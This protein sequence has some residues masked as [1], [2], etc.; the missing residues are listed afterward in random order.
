MFILPHAK[1]FIFVLFA[2]SIFLVWCLWLD[3]ESDKS[4]V[5]SQWQNNSWANNNQ[6]IESNTTTNNQ[7]INSVSDID[8]DYWTWKTTDSS[9]DKNQSWTTYSNSNSNKDKSSN[10]DDFLL[11]WSN[12]TSTNIRYRKDP[13]KSF[14]SEISNSQEL[15][16]YHFYDEEYVSDQWFI[17]NISK[18]QSSIPPNV[19]IISLNR[20]KYEKL[21]ESFNVNWP[22]TFV[23][24]QQWDVVWTLQLGVLE[25]EDL[26]N[27]IDKYTE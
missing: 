7:D 21:A 1:T 27:W 25:L 22:N 23:F 20:K 6:E 17:T 3:N 8:Q 11:W 26:Q 2:C 24:T 10:R 13:K 12:T 5:T 4:A 19:W 14:I 18:A 16:I 9:D 15:V